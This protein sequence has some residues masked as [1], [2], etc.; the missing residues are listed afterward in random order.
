MTKGTGRGHERAG[1]QERLRGEGMCKGGERV[2]GSACESRWA[3]G[4][5]YFQI[6]RWGEEKRNAGRDGSIGI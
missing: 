1:G 6:G 3:R 4:C 5:S 2:R